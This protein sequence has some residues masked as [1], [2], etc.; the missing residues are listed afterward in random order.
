MPK[1]HRAKLIIMSYARLGRWIN[2]QAMKHGA[3]LAILDPRGISS[4]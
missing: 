3:L 2:W 4:E 1:N